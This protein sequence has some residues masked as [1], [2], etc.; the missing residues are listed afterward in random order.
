MF[1]HG[2]FPLK[3]ADHGGSLSASPRERQTHISVSRLCKGTEQAPLTIR[4]CGQTCGSQE[5]ISPVAGEE[6]HGYKS[7]I[8]N[9]VYYNETFYCGREK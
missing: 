5:E 2:G 9:A 6:K 8:S 3:P 4:A 1:F 7:K